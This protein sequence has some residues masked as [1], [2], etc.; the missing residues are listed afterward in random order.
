MDKM[1][2][3]AHLVSLIGN[4]KTEDGSRNKTTTVEGDTF[5]KVL[6]QKTGR[7]EETAEK[8]NETISAEKS[9]ENKQRDKSPQQIEIEERL[10]GKLSMKPADMS[11]AN[12][13]YNIVLRNPD[14]LSLSE[15]QEFHLG[16]FAPEAVGVKEFQKMLSERGL[17]LR[18]L[19]MAQLA[20]LTQRNNKPQ[21]TAFLN[22]LLR[23]MRERSSVKASTMRML[24]VSFTEDVTE[25]DDDRRR[26]VAEARGGASARS[27]QPG[28][29]GAGAVSPQESTA[30]RTRH[31]EEQSRKDERENV[32][33]QIIQHMEIQSVGRRTDLTLKL[34]PEYL[35][36]MRVRLSSE[37]GKLEAAFET[38]SREVRTFIE[39]GW[40]GLRETFQRK[41]LNLT[42][43]TTKLVENIS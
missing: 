1:A 31:A 21:I 28:Q 18:D 11:M 14:T 20:Q 23:Q 13:L 17:H 10:K 2:E 33:R 16:D 40:E 36:E 15:K 4:T 19:S 43:V 12:Y 7:T 39:E 8:T 38:T 5:S 22:D 35:G 6:E 42:R 26:K 34:N 32:I 27:E 30:Q 24:N 3:N 9:A 29:H 25:K 37:N 41:G